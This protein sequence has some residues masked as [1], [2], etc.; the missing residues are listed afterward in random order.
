MTGRSKATGSFT[1]KFGDV[2]A[3]YWA[4]AYIQD[5]TQEGWAPQGAPATTAMAPPEGLLRG[6]V[7]ASGSTSQ[8]S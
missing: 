2:P 4:A 8:Y 1:S 5:A 7:R 6:A 3:G